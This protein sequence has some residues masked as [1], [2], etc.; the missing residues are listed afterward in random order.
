TVAGG[1]TPYT[2]IWSNGAS[3]QDLSGLS[4]GTYYVTVTDAQNCSAAASTT[5]TEPALLTAS[6]TQVNVSCFG[7]NNGSIDLTVAGGTAAYSYVWS[8][9]AATEDI[10]DLVA[11]TYIVSVTDAQ[12]CS[13]TASA[14]ITQPAALAASTTQVNVSCHGGNDGSI[15]LTVTGG[16][17]PYGYIWTTGATAQ[18]AGNLVAGTFTVTVTDAQG[19]SLT[20]SATITEP[21]VLTLFATHG[22]VSCHGGN[23]GSVN[24]TVT[25]GTTPYAYNW[26]NGATT[27]DI[28]A[29]ATGTYS[30]TVT[31]AQGCTATMFETV[32]QP[33]LLTA[34]STQVNV[35]CFGG[36]NGSID[37]SASGG[38]TPYSYSWSN[39]AITEDISSL[40]IGTYTATVT[41]AKS[42]TVTETA[43]IIQP[44]LL[45]ASTTQVNVS[46]NGGSNGS[47]D[48]SVAGGTPSYSYN[49][50]TG[51]TTQDIGGLFIGTYHVTVTDAQSCTVTTSAT[52]TEPS[53]L[54]G[55]ETHVDVS[56]KGGN[57][58]SIDITISGGT[59]PYVYDWSNGATTQ[60]ISGLTAGSY[61]VTVTDAK[62]CAITA[63]ISISE[64]ELLTAST[65]QTNVSCKS[66]SDGSIDL[67]VI[68][69]TAP[70]TF[71]WSNGATTED[72]SGLTIGTYT[73]T[74]T[75]AQGCRLT[76]SASITEPA[77]LTASTT[78]VDVSCRGGGDGSVNL[79][80]WGGTIPYSYLWSNGA[81][82][83]D[84]SGL[85]AGTYL[86]TVTDAK[87]C[88]ITVSATISEPASLASSTTQI[89]VS[90]NG[91]S[92]GSIDLTVSGGT[93]PYTYNWSIGTTTQD[94][95]S[96]IAG[97]YDVTITD[98]NGCSITDGAVITEP[99]VLTA[100]TVPTD[101]SCFGGND[102]MIDLSV[103]GGTT[104]YEFNWSNGATSEDIN[105]LIAGTY[106]VTV[107]D[108]KNC[109]VTQSET[110]NQP[111]DL[112]LTS[113]ANPAMCGVANGDASVSVTGGTPGYSY[114]WS[115]GDTD[116][117]ID[118]LS[119][120]AYTVTVTDANSCQKPLTVFVN[121]FPSA[122]FT[123]TTKDVTCHGG[124]DGEAVIF[125]SSG[126]PPYT[127]SWLPIGDNDSIASGL[128]VGSYT[129]VVYDSVGCSNSSPVTINEPPA[130]SLVLAVTDVSCFGGNDGAIDLAVSGSTPPYAYTWSNGEISQDISNL[131]IG[132]Y[133]VTITD[134]QGCETTAGA[135][136]TQPTALTTSLSVTDV[137]CNGGND[138]TINLTVSGGIPPYSFLWSNGA[139]TQNVSG[140]TAAN[141]SV[142]VTDAQ[143]CEKTDAASVSQPAALALTSTQQNAS[144]SGFSDGSIDITVTGGTTAYTYLWSAGETTED[145]D[146][147]PVGSYDVTV[148]DAHSCTITK[149]FV[150]TEPSGLAASI[151]KADVSCFGRNDGSIDVTASGGTAPYNFIWSNGAA[152]EDLSGIA[153][154]TYSVTVTDAQGCNISRST[155]I[156][157]PADLITS[158]S[159]VDVS[160]NGFSDGSLDLTIAGGTLPYVYNWSNGA[161]TQDLNGLV[162]GSYNVTVTDAQNC[163]VSTGETIT[164][165]AVLA[166]SL[167]KVDVR[168]NGGNNGSIDLNVSG[169]TTP[170]FYIWTNGAI[171]ED[172]DS[173]VAGTYTVTITDA[174]NCTVTA[175]T[176]IAEP[177]VLAMSLT[178]ADVSCNG[179]SDGSIDL[180]ISGGTASYV[181]T[182]SNG[183]VTEDLT[184]LTIGT[185]TVTVT[186]AQG[187]SDFNSVTIMQPAALTATVFKDDVNC[188]GGNDGSIDLTVGG[189]TAPYGFAWSNGDAAEDLNNL[190]TGSYSVTITD[191]QNCS[192]VSGTVITEPAVLSAS[193]SKTDVSCNGGNDGAI[194]LTVS[195]GTTDY[196]FL[197]SNG[198]TT[199]DL[200][201]IYEGSYTVTVTDAQACVLTTGTTVNA[202]DSIII[203]FVITNAT[204]HGGKDGAVDATVTGG[205]APYSYQWNFGPATQDISGVGAFTYMLT[206]TDAN[207]CRKAKNATVGEA[208]LIVIT[209]VS[210][211]PVSC[212]GGN[213]GAVDISVSGGVSPY[214]YLWS[215][216]A[217]T[218]DATGL[219]AG[220]GSVTVTDAVG[221][222][223]TRTFTITQPAPVIIATTGITPVTC[224]GG[225]N[226]AINITVSGG[227][228]GYTFS[229]SNGAATEDI[230]SLS[231]ATYT[232]TVT[233]GNNCTATKNILVTQPTAITFSFSVTHLLCNG[234][235]NGAINLTANGGTPGY[236][237]TWSNGATTE[238]ISGLVAGV[239]SVTVTDANACSAVN[240]TSVNQP[241]PIAISYTKVDVACNGANTAS[242]DAAVSGGTA[243]YRYAWSNGATTQ[244]ISSLASGSYTLTVTDL[245]NCRAN[246]TVFIS[247]PAAISIT[248]AQTDVSCN[249]G[250]TGSVNITVSGGVSPYTYLWSN[251]AT[252][253]DLSAIPV[254]SYTVTV[255]DANN[256]MATKTT[257]ITQ[258]P[259]LTVSGIVTNVLCSGSSTGSINITANGG[260][261]P[262]TFSWSTGVTTEDISNVPAGN[263]TITVSDAN[264]CSQAKSFTVGE[265]A[266]ISISVTSI[267]DA[268]CNGSAN[269][270]ITI[271]VSGGTT[272]YMYLWSNGATASAINNLSAG[273]Y[274]VTVTDANSCVKTG[275]YNIGQPAAIAVNASAISNAVCNSSST[276]SIAL[277]VSG[278]TPAYTYWW[279]TG[280]TTK[281]ISGLSAGTYSVTVTDAQN[282]RGIDSYNIGEPA[283]LDI[284]ITASQDARC[285]GAA[286]GSINITVSGGTPP[287]TYLWSTGATTE[288]ISALVAGSY[289]VTVTDASSCTKSASQ[290]IG[291]PP[292]LTV[293]VAGITNAACYGQPSGSINITV[294]GGTPPYSYLWSTGTTTEDISNVTAGSYTVTVT[295]AQYCSKISTYNIS[296]PGAVL[297]IGVTG[298]SDVKCNGA[299]TGY[300]NISVS[301]GTAPYTYLWSNGFTAQN[302]TGLVA[303]SYRVTVT[304]S[305]GCQKISNYNIGQPAAMAVNPVNIIHNNCNGGSNGSID[306]SVSG[307]TPPYTYLWSNGFSTQ[308][309]SGVASNSYTVTVTDANACTQTGTF[310]IG[311]PTVIGVTLINSTEISCNGGNNGA[312]DI[313]VS[314]G[315]PPY[316]YAWSTGAVSQDVISLA[317]GQ[318]KVTI[319]DA[320]GCVKQ[321]TFNIA[322]PNEIVISSASVSD[323]LCNGQASGSI[324]ISVSGGTAPYLFSWSNGTDT[325]DLRNASSGSYRVTV[326]DANGC[327]ETQSYTIGEPAAIAVNATSI[328]DNLCHG[329]STGAIQIVAH[330]GTAPYSY[331]WSNGITAQNISAVP[332]GTYAVT[333]T[334]AKG[335]AG[336]ET[337]EL[338]QPDELIV[339]IADVL[340]AKCNAGN[341]G[342]IKVSVSGGTPP[343][344]FK[345]SNGASAQNISALPAGVYAVTV[346]DVNYCK[347][348]AS[349]EVKEAASLSIITTQVAD[350]LCNDASNGSIDIS[351]SGGTP[352]YSY[353]WSNGATTQD[354]SG[355]S[356]G[357]YTVTVAD[358]NICNGV[359]SI[360]VSQPAAVSAANSIVVNSSCDVSEDGRVELNVSGGT[361]PFT[362]LW[363]TGATT[364]VLSNISKGNYSVTITDVNGCTGTNS[365]LLDAPSCNKPPVAVNDTSSVTTG[366]S[367]DIPVLSNDHDPDNDNISITG[368]IHEPSHG[369]ATVNS[370][371]TITYT[372]HPEYVGEDAFTYVI[373][374]DGNPQLCDTAIVFITIKPDKPDLFIPNAISPNNDESNEYW[375]I[376][377]IDLYP[378]NEVKIFNRWG[379]EVYRMNG[380][381]NQWN[382]VNQDRE[383]LPDGTYYYILKLNDK[384]K[385][386]YTGYVVIFRG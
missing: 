263:Y 227:T 386:T 235:S 88:T 250:N 334:D 204:C 131:T 28:S 59:P 196:S 279:S 200:N 327:V 192:L 68:G 152:T 7:G 12:S 105:M 256:C 186:D 73:V 242:I 23:D 181:F 84:I 116:D 101:V 29:L 277:T 124:S 203:S 230:N 284:T 3:T 179:N 237:F 210:I 375:E 205:I 15:D 282:C 384:Y 283:A 129:A 209:Q 342:E 106:T 286:N 22:D 95:S 67:S 360:A 169:G 98:A 229:W 153:I 251:G 350:A 233:D 370:D 149:N 178:K 347:D 182:W 248:A 97:V 118:S 361:P 299:A 323:A 56:C 107:V 11:G 197:W 127:Y 234:N 218:E 367:H 379:N 223:K 20:K 304:D 134:A 208:Q 48:L 332:A 236:S 160:C 378:H 19:C 214:T 142:T 158:I 108:A 63:T 307:G 325:E 206:V 36:S 290:N 382:G 123:V 113:S 168:C 99:P 82:T 40:P 52:I 297:T 226:G 14:I 53:A 33:P 138:G 211:T 191:A 164:E 185:Y 262:Y 383:P 220:A 215:N 75:D 17:T 154:G 285:N 81:T 369:T 43:T 316:S 83:E 175:G 231:S 80:V 35:N 45:T 329:D 319:T 64:P 254:G 171:T 31:D 137:N 377:G 65:T 261:T 371:G 315:T 295:D 111:T 373:C 55:S 71:S 238:D 1:T 41:D 217:T 46:C 245:N 372:P 314:G 130:Y 176:A 207:G 309:L 268:A 339:S 21:A 259:A 374:D 76:N 62:D 100:F 2:Y 165:P 34:S 195:G 358:G 312:V 293:T 199:E 341:D 78:H 345:W 265:P 92:D 243:P 190:A 27:E 16:T 121:S 66:G 86:V 114:L 322:E 10:S 257:S 117:Y 189:G 161:T 120:G 330:G 60:D 132:S 241:A 173:L 340:H 337:F 239:Y 368:I 324:D 343:Y 166:A 346:S 305:K 148:T 289:T 258:P 159:K 50:S 172:I 280:A 385:S 303:G 74:V 270:T 356:A 174:Q 128:T 167:A 313:D 143:A 272:P 201:G 310:G 348:S 288:D 150:I 357:T 198:A 9:G 4:A 157:E 140:L 292:V 255:S 103:T 260:I 366:Y 202:P 96:L 266:A 112:S 24:L 54:A 146:S 216:G 156:V 44:P 90:C 42:C 85:T 94:I 221:C 125:I 119:G 37:L 338:L 51:S 331:S 349:A 8:N 126:T 246:T 32:A 72:I 273:S 328:T 180:T 122:D 353:N 18:D 39:G 240:G 184:G 320:A 163:S 247:Q 300:I 115:T 30:V 5:I 333:V 77:Q 188:H 136:V 135:N 281:D 269:G 321:S 317:A 232:V 57:D 363:S 93:T 249:G 222:T 155:I 194:N 380:Y 26:N 355:L 264:A 70:Y 271:S 252:T 38:T 278:G 352:P 133:D 69:G 109:S 47:I 183:A 267:K 335:C 274:S 296:Q 102:G 147:L 275:N 219:T 162:I 376:R 318:H 364:A 87:S 354:I 298:I 301:G 212:N 170:Y 144:C 306:I 344:L 224:N 104:P 110:V 302:A 326:A 253:E 151:T 362:Y 141:Y 225:T 359:K 381:K 25:G 187:C 91:F 276:G 287:Y 145:I 291:E 213:D 308:D 351:V 13:V 336:G 228:P 6:A 89:N 244:D 365:F 61:N 177:N 311:E 193:L 139:A 49:W 294:S 79:S 58:G